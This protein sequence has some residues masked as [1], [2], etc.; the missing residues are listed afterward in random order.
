VWLGIAASFVSTMALVSAKRLA[1]RI[2][3]ENPA[4]VRPTVR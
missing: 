1:H 2:G 3:S 4:K